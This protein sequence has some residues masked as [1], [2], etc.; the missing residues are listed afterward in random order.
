MNPI[1]VKLLKNFLI[2]LSVF[3]FIIIISIFSINAL[4]NKLKNVIEERENILTSLITQQSINEQ[5]VLI[6]NKIAEIEKK[7]NIKIE[8]IKNNILNQK[9]M[10]K[11][12]VKNLIEDIARK[13]NLKIETSEDI[14]NLISLKFVGNI[15]DVVNI[16]KEL[17]SRNH[18][19]GISEAN[20]TK[21]ENGYHIKLTIS[22]F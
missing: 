11:D 12:E 7:Y 5:N 22:I 20:L 21:T 6:K 10:S 1:F 9:P 17:K 4:S 14:P 19:I 16:E 8:D 18:N 15:E 13:Y 2:N 3:L